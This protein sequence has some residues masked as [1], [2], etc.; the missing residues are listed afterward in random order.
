MCCYSPMRVREPDLVL[1]DDGRNERSG[2]M[3]KASDVC[4]R[5]MQ[6]AWRTM[7]EKRGSQRDGQ[8]QG[9]GS[10]DHAASRSRR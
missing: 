3:V 6:R 10:K 5:V 8:V 4:V 7:R 1:A 9:G 2:G